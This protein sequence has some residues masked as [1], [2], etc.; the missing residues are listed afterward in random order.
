MFK[1]RYNPVV[2]R[3]YGYLSLEGCNIIIFFIRLHLPDDVTGMG[4]KRTKN[5][6]KL[7]LFISKILLEFNFLIRTHDKFTFMRQYSWNR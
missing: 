6:I 7:K 2:N 1:Q 3:T 5:R 4:K